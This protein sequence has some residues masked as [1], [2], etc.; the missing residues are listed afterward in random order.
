M[1]EKYDFELMSLAF[2]LS[3]IGRVNERF[4]TVVQAESA[5]LLG[6][7]KTSAEYS[8]ILSLLTSKG[9]VLSPTQLCEYTLQ[10]PSGMTKTLRR[11]ENDGLIRRFESAEDARYS[12]V[13][14][15]PAGRKLAQRLMKV[16]L[17]GYKEV[18]K[19]LSARQFSSMVKTLR[20]VRRVL[21]KSFAK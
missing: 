19:D 4:H 16:T 11:L 14:L 5:E 2:S 1:K 15:T 3:R 7:K 18:F 12:M 10:T 20:L 9:E 6:E 13:Q 8:V 21:E 17:S